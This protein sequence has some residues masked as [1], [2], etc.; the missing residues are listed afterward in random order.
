M[1]RFVEG[2][3]MKSKVAITMAENYEE[4][5]RAVDEAIQLLG[6]PEAICTSKDVVMIK[7]NMILPKDPGMAETTHPAVVAA[8]VK[9]LKKTGAVVKV[10]EQAA[11]HYDTKAAFEATGIG[12]AALEAGADEVVN[13]QQDER[14]AVKVPDPRSIQTAYLPVSVVESDVFIHVPKMKTNYYYGSVTL[15]IKGLLGL[16]A[17]KDR[18]IY[19]RTIAEM[20]WATCDLAKAIA[21][22]HRL[23]LIDGIT[24]MEGGG[25]H[26]G[27]KVEPGV[28]LASQDMVAVE[29]VGCTIMGFHPFESPGVQVAMKA[30][31]GTGE[32]SEIEILGKTIQEATK[33]PFKR[34]I[35]RLVSKWKNVK[36]YI[37]GTCEGCLLGLTRT[38]FTVNP[39]KIYAII[40]GTRALVPDHL[41]ADE[42][43]LVGECACRENH[44]F[45]GFI[46]KISH[47]KTIHKF[48]ACP[49][50]IGFHDQYK[51]P[52]TKGTPYQIPD[53]ITVDGSTLAILPD[54][55]RESDREAAEMRRE[56]KMSLDEAKREQGIE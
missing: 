22:K 4:A 34:P 54:L 17:N 33:H 53:L 15:A 2:I 20:A 28:I 21:P 31:L 12:K 32:L 42:V 5:E 10:G 40:A 43:W 11:W 13:W 16:L 44:Q 1:S 46:S 19:H 8:L 45:P 6:G 29:A 27:L 25:P 30:G 23:T 50:I 26:A 24:G 56:G 49:G 36:E 51:R 37:G 35:R 47:V 14:V 18:G 9:A 39:N 52:I 38:P 48:P 3:P 7:P 55:V 41:E